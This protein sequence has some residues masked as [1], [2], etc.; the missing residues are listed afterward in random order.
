MTEHTFSAA[1]V[2][3]YVNKE[4]KETYYVQFV[5][6]FMKEEAKLTFKKVKQRP[7][8]V[9][10]A[11]IKESRKLFASKLGKLLTWETLVIYID[12]SSINRHIKNLYSWSEKGIQKKQSV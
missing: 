6:A 9:N 7:S 11:K 10:F 12:E 2:T 1:N 3:E 4:I 5:R 8:S